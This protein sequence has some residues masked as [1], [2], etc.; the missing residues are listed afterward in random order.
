VLRA[1]RRLLRP[2]GRTGF[3]TIHPAPDLTAPQRR[4]ASRTG[5]VA[6]ATRRPHRHL[7]GSAGFI[8]IEERDFTEE[9][10]ATTR[11]WMEQ[12]DAH[13]ADLVA[14]LG[15][16]VVDDR[17]RERRAQLRAIEDGILCRSLFSATRPPGAAVQIRRG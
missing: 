15:S 10:A 14:L 3:L 12:W 4:R 8:G 17:Q 9:F 6:V 2:G 13:R 1:C 5:P 16:T 11:A 7:L